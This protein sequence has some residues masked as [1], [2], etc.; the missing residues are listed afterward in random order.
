MRQQA[1]W[2]QHQD[3]PRGVGEG[4]DTCE[5]SERRKAGGGSLALLLE[6][7]E[8]PVGMRC[9]KDTWACLSEPSPGGPQ[10]PVFDGTVQRDV[11]RD[12]HYNTTHEEPQARPSAQQRREPRPLPTN[13]S[14][15]EKSDASPGFPPSTPVFGEPAVVPSGALRGFTT[16]RARPPPS[17]PPLPSVGG[18]GGR[19]PP[20]AVLSTLP[21]TPLRSLKS[22]HDR[23]DSGR[24][25]GDPS[26]PPVQGE[27]G[28]WKVSPTRTKRAAALAALESKAER[29]ARETS[30]L[31][32]WAASTSGEPVAGL[33][34]ANAALAARNE[35]LRRWNEQLQSELRSEAG[36]ARELRVHNDE[37][38]HAMRQLRRDESIN[39]SPGRSPQSEGTEGG[40]E[41]R[42]LTLEAKLADKRGM[43][44]ALLSRVRALVRGEEE[45]RRK[46][47]AEVQCLEAKLNQAESENEALRGAALSR[48]DVDAD[49]DGPTTAN[50]EAEAARLRVLSEEQQE[51]LEEQQERTAAAQARAAAAEEEARQKEEMV[52]MAEATAREAKDR[53]CEAE[54]RAAE[55]EGEREAM[56]DRTAQLED[57]LAEL[58]TA[59]EQIRDSRHRETTAQQRELE[60]EL[61]E[62]RRGEEALRQECEELRRALGGGGDEDEEIAQR[63]ATSGAMADCLSDLLWLADV[64]SGVAQSNVEEGLLM[65]NCESSAERLR[66]V[67]GASLREVSDRLRDTVGVAKIAAMDG[68]AMRFQDPDGPG[69]CTHQ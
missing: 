60:W 34:T 54:E 1:L 32:E 38:Q 43:C 29:L 36:S 48:S 5:V 13:I 19:T 21:A 45:Q 46:H 68:L 22:P 53:L 28:L 24:I 66:R 12:A 63:S 4:L 14:V 6:G 27:L 50:L 40:W 69:S 41:S 30:A 2:R 65:G 47:A 59:V 15:S 18:M 37:L 26:P 52:R 11:H 31:S 39:G 64:I 44:E 25:P 17:P 55:A 57:Q 56:C 10:K 9:R 42:A 20:D 61:Q 51:R 58:V 8:P 35:D 7:L 49:H 33:K 67:R 16:G 62:A 3:P 23:A